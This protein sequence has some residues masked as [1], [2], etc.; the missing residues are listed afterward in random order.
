MIYLLERMY[1]TGNDGSQNFLV[2]VPMP[3]SLILD[4]NKKVTNWISTRT[5]SEKIKP[6]DT[7]FEPTISNLIVCSYHVTYAIQSESTLCSCLNVQEPFARNR[8]NI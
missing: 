2:F 5:S 1:F 3:S 4:S 6:I 7:N 8:R